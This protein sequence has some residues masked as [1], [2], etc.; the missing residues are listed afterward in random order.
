MGI[1]VAVSI[2]IIQAAI[3]MAGKMR[4]EN[5]GN[6]VYLIFIA[7]FFAVVFAYKMITVSAA[8]DFAISP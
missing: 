4:K 7:L 8:A 1:R 2:L 3:K 6:K 5:S